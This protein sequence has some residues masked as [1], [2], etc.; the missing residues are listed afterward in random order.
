M[1][2]GGVIMT[3]FFARPRIRIAAIHAVVVLALSC[4]APVMAAVSTLGNDSPAFADGSSPGILDVILAQSSSP[5]P[6]DTGIGSD[7]FENFQA[8]WT[9]TYSVAAQPVSAASI[10][11][12]IV[13]GDSASPGSQVQSFS[14]D[15]VDLTAALNQAMNAHGGKPGEYDVY[16]VSVP[17]TAFAQLLDGSASVSLALTGPVDAPPPLLAEFGTSAPLP[18]NGASLI[19]SRLSVTQTPVPE[20]DTLVLL[21]TGL[22]LG[23][24]ALRRRARRPIGNTRTHN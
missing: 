1:I 18:Y 15:G 16:T 5:A 6:F 14:V 12:G 3:A 19:F 8:S 24:F 13:G 2:V 10:A 9:H 23:T 11:I 4:S 22:A 21:G 20:P 17:A 7:L